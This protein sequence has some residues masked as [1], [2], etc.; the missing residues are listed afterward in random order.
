MHIL[1]DIIIPIFRIS[2]EFL[3]RALDSISNQEIDKDLFEVFVVDGTPKKY[4]DYNAKELV[5]SYG[6]NF[7]YL[8]Q[9]PDRKLVGGARNQGVSVGTNP[10]LA[11][12]DGDDY[13]YA[14]YLREMAQEIDSS[15]D[16][17]SIWTCALD[18]EFPIFSSKSGKSVINKVYGYYP[19]YLSFLASHP[20]FAYYWLM[21]HPPAPTG[22]IIKRNVFEEANGYDE[23]LGIIEDTELLLRIVGDPRKVNEENRNHYNF[24]SYVGG[25]HYIGE[26]NTT[27]RGT[28]SGVSELDIEI[29]E[30]FKKNAEKFITKHPKPKQKDMPEGTPIG[31]FESTKGV[32]R[33]RNLE[34]R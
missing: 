19:E 12:L 8:C 29:E 5:G 34:I 32:M 24:V 4:Q 31:F 18:C 27:N 10:Y 21:G 17:A 22:T 26:E 7:F 11:F 28:Q 30:Y 20:S 9:S 6:K 15:D 23:E 2:E 33:E 13:W 25:Y 14:S 3:I 16:K 1:F